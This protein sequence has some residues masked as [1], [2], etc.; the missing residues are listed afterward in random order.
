MRSLRNA[1]REVDRKCKKMILYGSLTLIGENSGYQV[2]G[3]EKI[4]GAIISREEDVDW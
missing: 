4:W 2:E 1:D 3:E